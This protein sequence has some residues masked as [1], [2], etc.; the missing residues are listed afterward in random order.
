[1]KIRVVTDSTCDLPLEV[2]EMY[3]LVVV[4]V[5][6]NMNGKSYLDGVEISRAEFYEMLP[7]SDPLP[8]TSAPGIGTFVEIYK[9][10]AEEGATY[11]ISIHISGSLSN[12]P[13]IA[14]LAAEA[15]EE[16]QVIVVDSGQL[17]LGLGLVALEAAQ[18]AAGELS[19]DE[20]LEKIEDLKKRTHSY[21][22]LDTLD[23][24]KKGGRISALQHNLATLLSIKPLLL[25]YQ[26]DMVME[27]VRT[28]KKAVERMLAHAA[29][30]GKLE[31]IALVHASSI[32]RLEAVRDRARELFADLEVPFSGE[33]TPAIGSHVGPGSV[34]LVCIVE[35]SV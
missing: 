29:S 28:H 21:A 26:G 25:F 8:T 1:M 32:E 13:N 6:I 9:K 16:V 31:K 2:A 4:P 12:I 35:G 7:S 19:L 10:L 3:G 27:K 14:R 17:T 33:V 11:I 23:Y 34:G 5:F 18:M 30:L 22:L 20:V 24:L 15:V